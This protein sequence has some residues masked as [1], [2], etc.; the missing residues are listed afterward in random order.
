MT[1]HFEILAVNGR[2]YLDGDSYENRDEFATTVTVQF[3]NQKTAYLSCMLNDGTKGRV[4]SR[5]W[6][7]LRDALYRQFGVELIE[8]ERH[9]EQREYATRPAPL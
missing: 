3:R 4:R 2:R 1:W 5:D 6:L 9:S 7:E 8:T